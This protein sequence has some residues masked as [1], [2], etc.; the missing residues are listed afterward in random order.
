MAET[1]AAPDADHVHHK[2][3]G[4]GKT[5]GFNSL[6][7]HDGRGMLFLRVLFRRHGS[8]IPR[9][10]PIALFSACVTI[11]LMIC[12]KFNLV[13]KEYL[14]ILRH[15]IAVQMLGIVLGYVVVLRSN[16]SVNRY[17]EGISNV[18][19]FG[20][21]WVDALS[22]LCAFIRT[23]A[24]MH[25]RA[26]RE[27]MLDKLQDLQ[28]DL[29]HWF[30]MLHALAINSLQ[31]TQ[32]DLD[33]EIFLSRMNIVGVPEM[34]LNTMKLEA[35]SGSQQPS[36]PSFASGKKSAKRST[37]DVTEAAKTTGEKALPQLTVLGPLTDH[38]EATL[39][40][41]EDKVDLVHSWILESI[42]MATLDQVILTQSPIVSRVYQELSNG[43]LGYNQ[44]YKIAL[45]QF[46]FAFAQM[47]TIFLLAFVFACPIAIF[48]FTGGEF[49]TPALTL[50]TVLGFWGI[51]EIAVEVENPFGISANQLPMKPL[52][53]SVCVSIFEACMAIKPDRTKKAPASA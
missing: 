33:Q 53:D 12:D 42:S 11:V 28:S 48:V 18:Q 16:V 1:T 24:I 32:L 52:H 8:I 50:F 43:M 37:V 5:A 51:H 6:H 45:V 36:S 44:A 25:K 46:P 7:K 34:D 27:H 9:T 40:A 20:S 41:A 15:P 3:F 17:F 22:Q 29:L 13:G 14:P 4:N 31:T 21:K 38:E 23:S 19:F 30:S 26:G 47:L 49:L 39:K 10:L 2:D 35:P